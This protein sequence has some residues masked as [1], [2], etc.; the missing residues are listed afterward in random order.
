E[1]GPA[2]GI[3]RQGGG[4]RVHLPGV[5]ACEMTSPERN[6]SCPRLSRN[7]SPRSWSTS[8]AARRGGRPPRCPA[9]SARSP[10]PSLTTGSA[11]RILIPTGWCDYEESPTRLPDQ[12][13]AARRRAGAD[14]GEGL[15]GHLG[16]GDLRGGGADQG[17]LF[18]LFPGKGAPG[19][20][21]RGAVL[22]LLAGTV[23]GGAFSP[24]AR[25][26]GSR[27]RSRRF[28]HR[29]VPPPDV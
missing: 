1:E 4:R 13:E 29:N 19:K 21:G 25:P 3:P 6:R 16:R 14:V 2:R 10:G 9:S 20:N 15:H 28:L 24:K 8:F 23:P 27:P 7:R 18:P 12:A 22:R 17:E 26:P 5:Q 11:L